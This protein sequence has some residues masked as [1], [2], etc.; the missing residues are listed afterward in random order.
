MSDFDSVI[1]GLKGLLNTE[2]GRERFK[3]IIEAAGGGAAESMQ[4]KREA[5]QTPSSEESPQE[6]RI[7]N[8]APFSEESQAEPQ[9]ATQAAEGNHLLEN[10]GTIL[11][12]LSGI[13]G[14]EKP[15]QTAATPMPYGAS[16][17]A[18]PDGIN[19]IMGVM[20]KISAGNEPRI[21]LLMALR[22]YLS[23][24]RVQSLDNTV[25]V[26]NLTKIGNMIQQMY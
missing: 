23:A 8:Q 22:P 21:N 11:Q 20:D 13:T 6:G 4:D 17:G 24:K 3:N 1:S 19:K 14:N 16:K 25:K 12:A 9:P 15:V 7:V 18:V 5:N 26:L 10:I 2:E